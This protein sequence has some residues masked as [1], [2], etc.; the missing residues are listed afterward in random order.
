MTAMAV[1]HWLISQS[2]FLARINQYDYNYV[3]EEGL[4]INGTGW[5]P[6]A[7]M[8]ALILGGL[9]I[10]ALPIFGFKRLPKKM[11]LAG[12]NSA[13]M[14][15]ACHRQDGEDDDIMQRP[16]QYGVLRSTDAEG[17]K[18]AGFSAEEVSPLVIGEIYF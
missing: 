1:L 6:I 7:L 4:T 12:S 15:A 16:L 11:P 3:L 17:R 13:A 5:S 18:R 9:M 10:L 14:S 2:T 8:F